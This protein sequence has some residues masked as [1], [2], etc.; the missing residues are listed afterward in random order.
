VSVAVCCSSVLQCAAVYSV[1]HRLEVSLS[2]RC[3]VLHCVALCSTVL[4]CV[5]LW[6]RRVQCSVLCVLHWVRRVKCGV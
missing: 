6:V 2:V 1:L 5:A 3:S 4:H